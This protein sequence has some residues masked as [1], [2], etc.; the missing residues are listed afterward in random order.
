MRIVIAG[1]TGFLG[2]PLASALAADGHDVV[3]L[4]RSSGG[5]GPRRVAW[6]PDGTA[7]PWASVVDGAGAVVN[8][9]GESIAARRRTGAQK[10]RIL[11]SRADAAAGLV[12]AIEEAS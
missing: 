10:N 11:E 6:A 5:D 12:E 3:A 7:G 9:A 4:S 8:L 1:G 2:R